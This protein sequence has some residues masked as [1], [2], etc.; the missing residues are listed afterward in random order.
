MAAMR[1]PIGV[2]ATGV[3]AGFSPR[4]PGQSN[5]RGFSL[6]PL[7]LAS[8]AVS[9]KGT[10]SEPVLSEAEWMPQRTLPTRGALAPGVNFLEAVHGW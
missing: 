2:A 10:A 6:G 9:L 4:E 1:K 8:S 5:R 7:S 3:A